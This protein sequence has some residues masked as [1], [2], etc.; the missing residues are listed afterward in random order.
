[1]KKK[2]EKNWKNF[3]LNFVIHFLVK[4]SANNRN[5]YANFTLKIFRKY[6]KL[7]KL[8]ALPYFQKKFSKFFFRKFSKNYK[9]RNFQIYTITFDF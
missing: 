4:K 3:F 1:M 8:Q 6:Q 9:F 2:V 7:T 5:I